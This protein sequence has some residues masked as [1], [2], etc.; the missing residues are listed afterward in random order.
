[1]FKKITTSVAA[2]TMAL[3]LGLTSMSQTADARG[4]RTAAIVG[5]GV[6]G[7]LAIGAA[8]ANAS[9][10]TYYRERCYRVGG[11][12]HWREGRCYINRHGDE[13]CS[14]GYKVCE[15]ARTVCD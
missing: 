12:C 7:A 4:G 8:S 9:N 11:G 1:M 14:R 2:L 6:L 15:P 5:L 10:R 3:G 13:V